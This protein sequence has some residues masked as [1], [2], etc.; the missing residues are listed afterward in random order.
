MTC[1]G[2]VALITGSTGEGIGRSTAFVLARRGADIVLNFGTY[3][4]DAEFEQNAE[5]VISAIRDMGRR[6]ILVKADTR[7]DEE[8]SLLAETALRE[9][10]RVDI[11]VNN[12]GGGWQP[13]DYTEIPYEHWRQVLAAEIDGAFLTMKYL[14]P[15]M[16]ER[17]WGRIIHIGLDNAL[18][19]QNLAHLAPDYCLGKAVRAWMTTAFGPQEFPRNITVNCIEPGPTAHMSFADALRAAQGDHSDWQPPEGPCAH[20]VAEII[21]FLCSP[22]ARFISGSTIRLPLKSGA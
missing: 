18:R 22:A 2:K 13:R 4:R 1:E 21:A 19:M 7:R 14:I 5:R 20:D 17:R 6:A 11:L 3:H 10:G 12:A 16:R 15:R 8:V 9:F